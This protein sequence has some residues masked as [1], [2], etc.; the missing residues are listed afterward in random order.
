MISV[1]LLTK[2]LTKSVGND[3]VLLMYDVTYVWN[4]NTV[5]TRYQVTKYKLVPVYTYYYI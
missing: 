1:I 4:I 3:E 5:N 2:V